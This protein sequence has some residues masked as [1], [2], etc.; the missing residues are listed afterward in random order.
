MKGKVLAL[1]YGSKRIG[2]AISSADRSLCFVRAFIA[3]SGALEEV[4][5]QILALI[6]AENVKELLVG[7]PFRTEGDLTKQGQEIMAFADFLK[8][9]I[10][11]LVHV[12]DESF[13]TFEAQEIMKEAKLKGEKSMDLKDS[14]SAYVILRNWLKDNQ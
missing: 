7:V 3:N 5:S 9:K 11:I 10:K 12:F 1:D 4:L 8:S 14:F 13:S 6:E 2:V